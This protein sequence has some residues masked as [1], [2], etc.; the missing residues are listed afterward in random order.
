MD[1]RTFISALAG[2]LVATPLAGRAQQG[3]P[4]RLGWLAIEPLPERLEVFVQG[5]RDLGYVEHAN[6]VLDERYGYG[7]AE[8]LPELA[9]DLVRLKPDALI[10]IGTPASLAAQGATTTVPIVFIVGDPVRSKLVASLSHPGANLTGLTIITTE[11]NGKRVELL[12]EAVPSINRIAVLTDVAAAA[13]FGPT[14]WREIETAASSK[15]IQLIPA[16]DVRDTEDLDAA[17]ATAIKQRADGMLVGSSPVFGSWRKRIVA[18]AAKTRLPVIYELRRFVEIGGLM[19]YGPDIDGI[20]RRAA[21]YVDKILK[22]T[23]PADLPV[24]QPAKV[25]L[26]INLKTAKALGLTIPPSLRLRADE[27]IE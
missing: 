23:K 4:V 10:T 14:S 22:G 15:A 19:S 12:K 26:V 3:R 9:A 21:I 8:R 5:L 1:R 24:E 7:R 16:L 18:L 6:L 25:E 17:F 27:V 2:G 20:V 13:S 11:L